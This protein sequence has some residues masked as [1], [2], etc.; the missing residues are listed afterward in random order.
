MGFSALKEKTFGNQSSLYQNM[1][2]TDPDNGNLLLKNPWKNDHEEPLN[3]HEVKFL[4][5]FLT[6][7]N[8]DRVPYLAGKELEKAR[9]DSKGEYF[10]LPLALGKMASS[11][12]VKGLLP[13]LK[14]RL[15]RWAP[16]KVADSVKESEGQV[17]SQEE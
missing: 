2:Y 9:M 3:S 8:K 17:F 5:F 10:Y 14:D 1:I 7:I 4:K 16:K 11:A 13:A 12:A 15:M 6:E